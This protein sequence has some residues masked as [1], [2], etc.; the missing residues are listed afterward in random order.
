MHAFGGREFSL[1]LILLSVC[2]TYCSS[3]SLEG[4]LRY[5][6]YLRP[7]SPTV[8]MTITRPATAQEAPEI[9]RETDHDAI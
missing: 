7:A 6:E 5:W 2:V 4:L 1:G 9:N 3:H 8:M